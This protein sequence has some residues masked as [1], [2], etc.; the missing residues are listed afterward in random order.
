M[1]RGCAPGARIIPG[2]GEGATRRLMRYKKTP[3]CKRLKE[4]GN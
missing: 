2:I 4:K 1:W 3:R